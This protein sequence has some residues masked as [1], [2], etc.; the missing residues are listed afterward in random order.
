MA[1]TKKQLAM[2]D[3]CPVLKGM[4][5]ELIEVLGVEESSSSDTGSD[6]ST[7]SDNLEKRNI[8][9]SVTDGESP[10]NGASVSL[11]KNDETIVSG[12]TGSAGGCTLSNVPLD[13]YAVLVT[14]T[15]YD[16]YESTISVTSE[17]SSLTVTMVKKTTTP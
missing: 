12:T 13:N 2:I 15:G 10:V 1:L 8:T 5:S 4:K 14:A 16:D 11:L 9:V 17:T 6:S 7:S 3:S